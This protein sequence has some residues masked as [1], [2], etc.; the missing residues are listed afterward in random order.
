MLNY[1]LWLF[2][3]LLGPAQF[4]RDISPAVGDSSAWSTRSG[5]CSSLFTLA[6]SVLPNARW[7]RRREV[8][9]D[10]TTGCGHHF[11]QEKTI[12][13]HHF[14]TEKETDRYQLVTHF[15]LTLPTIVESCRSPVFS[16]DTTLGFAFQFLMI[17]SN[18]PVISMGGFQWEVYYLQ[19]RVY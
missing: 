9:C 5:G 16:I 1:T 15:L 19:S 6:C 7:K 14:P 12:C 18:L 17:F 3:L 10:T 2:V 8:S 11:Q 4:P 13:G